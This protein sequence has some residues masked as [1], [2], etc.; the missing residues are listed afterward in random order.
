[1]AWGSHVVAFSDEGKSDIHAG[2]Q[3]QTRGKDAG[4]S[5]KTSSNF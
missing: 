4:A 1:M 2:Q 5:M 3:R